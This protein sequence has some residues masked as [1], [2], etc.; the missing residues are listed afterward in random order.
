M[1]PTA[2]MASRESCRPKLAPRYFRRAFVASLLHILQYSCEF[3]QIVETLGILLSPNKRNLD[4]PSP[5]T[6]IHYALPHTQLQSE[7]DQTTHR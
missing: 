5:T 4:P 6:H 3:G 1:A 7:R 2:F